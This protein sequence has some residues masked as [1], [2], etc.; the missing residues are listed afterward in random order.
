MGAWGSGNF[1]N[2]AALDVI[3]DMVEIAAAEIT[4]FCK[5]DRCTVEDLDALMGCVAAH[6]ALHEH[7]GGARPELPVAKALR[8]KVIDLYDKSVDSLKPQADYKRAR[9]AVLAATLERYE[10]MAGTAK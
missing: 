3:A 2:D 9:R 5:S 4:A 6:M 7:C 10:H 8:E 1:D